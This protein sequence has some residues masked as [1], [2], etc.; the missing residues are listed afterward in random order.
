MQQKKQR[1]NDGKDQDP[2]SI[3]PWIMQKNPM[4]QTA[5]TARKAAQLGSKKSFQKLPY[6][7]V[8]YKKHSCK[9]PTQGSQKNSLLKKYPAQKTGAIGKKESI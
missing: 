9:N 5:Q 4:K 8:W 1:K 6:R 7:R 2:E 3:H